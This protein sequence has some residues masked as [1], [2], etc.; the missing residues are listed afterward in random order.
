MI[1]FATLKS[2][3]CCRVLN[4]LKSFQ[5]IHLFIIEKI[6]TIILL[7]KHK[8]TE[9]GFC[10]IKREKVTNGTNA[11]YVN[12]DLAADVLYMRVKSH[13]ICKMESE[14]FRNS[15]E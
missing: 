12:V 14:V 4:L 10:Y 1:L 2:Y 8:G 9:Q 15:R 13:V 3:S 11:S 6:I 5:N 7:W